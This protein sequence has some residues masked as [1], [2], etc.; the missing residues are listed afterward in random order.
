M[1]VNRPSTAVDTVGKVQQGRGMGPDDQLTGLFEDLEQQAAGLELTDRDAEV[2]DRT[3]AEYAEVTLMS[4]VRGSVGARVGLQ[5]VGAGALTGRV[6]RAGRDWLLLT[7]PEGGHEWVVC[8]DA[9]VAA[10]GLATAS[11]AERVAAV[12][13]RLGLRSVL[14]GLAES[15]V[16]LVAHHRDGTRHRGTVVRVGAD[17]TELV[18]DGGG[19]GWTG[20]SGAVRVLPYAQLS[21]LRLLR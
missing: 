7:S 19:P 20:A 2:A 13:A 12:T 15:R 17:F 1:L 21:A 4:R 14:R 8:V 3:R 16:E 10:T 9:V 5:L 18:V 6:A 11:V